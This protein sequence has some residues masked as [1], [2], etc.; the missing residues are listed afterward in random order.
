MRNMIH[1]S[2][3]PGFIS[4]MNK[5]LI[6]LFFTLASCFIG[7]GTSNTSK[8]NEIINHKWWNK[9]P[10]SKVVNSI[11][12]LVVDTNSGHCVYVDDQGKTSVRKF[13]GNTPMPTSEI[14]PR[15][16]IVF[17]EGEKRYTKEIATQKI[18]TALDNVEFRDGSGGN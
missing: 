14:G 9:K 15:R 13:F 5:V 17:V 16:F 2:Y 11:I 8:T 1:Y 4:I 10:S 12:N 18:L 6:A 3:F 7:C